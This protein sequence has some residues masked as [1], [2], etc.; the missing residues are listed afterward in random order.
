MATWRGIGVG[1]LIAGGA[2]FALGGCASGPNYEAPP[3]AAQG[4]FAEGGPASLTSAEAPPDAWWRLFHDE[5]LDGLVLQALERNRDLLQAESNLRQARGALELARSSEFPKSVLSAGATQGVSSASLLASRLEGRGAP[6]AVG[7]FT[8]G[9]D[10]SFEVDL[11]G[12]IRRSV[13]AAKADVGAAAALEDAVRVSVA[14]ETVRAYLNA[15]AYAQAAAVAQASIAVATETFEITRRQ[16]ELGAASDFDLARA[17]AALEQARA[18][19]PTLEGQR[20]VALFQLSVLTG[21]PPEV[22]DAAAAACVAPPKLTAPAP[23]GDVRDLIRRRP[24]VRAAERRLAAAVSRIGVAVADLYPT[25]SLGASGASGAGA[26][27]GLGRAS[28]ATYSLGPVLSWTIP[29]TLAAQAR[30]RQAKAVASGAYAA[31]DGTVLTA[32]QDVESALALYRADLER[33]RALQ[34][35]R[36]AAE[37]AFNLANDQYKA[38]A[39]SYLEL[40]TAQSVFLEARQALALSEAAVASDQATLF[41]ALGGGWAQAPAVQPL[42]PIPGRVAARSPGA[43]TP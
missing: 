33:N 3:P 16:T 10:A 8:A 32:L 34:S 40:I 24:D 21:R 13:E 22:V 37:R 29:N 9:L 28:N 41:K 25:I 20:R 42:D 35:A 38:G 12:R 26:L 19:A 4:R 5:A 15:C 1:L 39:A 31:F 23:V 14:G 6:A 2:L 27:A 18:Q 7:G 30:I 36:D 17:K 43:A 11:F